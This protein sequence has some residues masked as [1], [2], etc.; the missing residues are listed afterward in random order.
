MAATHPEASRQTPY[1]GLTPFNEGDARYF[2]GREKRFTTACR[3]SVCSATHPC[4]RRKRRWEIFRVWRAGVLPLLRQRTDVLPVI[5]SGWQSEP[6]TGIKSA[7]ATELFA[8]EKV[9]SN[10]Y[11]S[12]QDTVLFNEY[13][14]LPEFLQKVAKAAKRRLLIIL[15]QFE[16][17]AL[18]QTADKN[19]VTQFARA[20][21][22]KDLS[23]SF[24][25]SLREEALARL[26]R[27][28]EYIP[29]LFDSFRRIDHLEEEAARLAIV[30]PLK[31]FAE[32]ARP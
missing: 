12:H 10:K 23:A 13:D 26:D 27:F 21:R 18:Y 11:R 28:E 2:F 25:L 20:T 19:F 7:V 30:A 5:F 22:L 1:Q 9:G 29:T 16:E 3:R 17:S 4:L 6:I 8:T 31:K 32:D 15:D 14:E 24:I